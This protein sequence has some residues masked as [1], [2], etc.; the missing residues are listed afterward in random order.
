MEMLNQLAKW[1]HLVKNGDL[2]HDVVGVQGPRCS[3]E[4]R[5]VAAG[6]SG[7]AP[8]VHLEAEQL[9]AHLEE[10][11]AEP[12]AAAHRPSQREAAGGRG[13]GVRVWLQALG[14]RGRKLRLTYPPQADEL[15]CS[16]DRIQ[17]VEGGE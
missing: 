8:G 3:Q 5:D 14:R 10:V 13:R 17:K 9:S 6:I 16:T 11:T 15:H 12:C 4:D 1:T 7:E 2:I